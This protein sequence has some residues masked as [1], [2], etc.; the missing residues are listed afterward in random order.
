MKNLAASISLGLCCLLVTSAYSQTTF[1]G[2]I[3]ND[4]A[5]TGNWSNGLPAEGND[6]TIPEGL[7]VENSGVVE[8]FG[9]GGIV[10]PST[11][12]SNYGTI[13]NLATIE[14]NGNIY[15][16][17]EGVISNEGT[18]END[19]NIS[20]D[21]G[22]IHNSAFAQ[23]NN[24]LG[25]ITNISGGEIN[26]SGAIDNLAYGTILNLTSCHIVNH[27][28]IT[29][30]QGVAEISNYGVIDNY[31]TISNFENVLNYSGAVIHQC[32]T[33]IGSGPSWNDYTTENCPVFG[34]TDSTACNYDLSAN[35][36]DG[37]CF[38]AN[39]VFDC[40]GNCQIDLN[41]NGV[42]DQL[43]TD[44]CSGPGCCGNGTLWDPGQGVCV[45]FDQCPAD[46]NEDQVVDA[47]DILALIASYGSDC[48]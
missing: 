40:E 43:E 4:W 25:S 48:P 22:A 10:T 19:G 33:W 42:C 27:G 7:T 29:N 46:V 37:S 39:A 17:N 30:H 32:G 47:L 41:N 5:D 6:A 14:N 21:G 24:F 11:T 28:T 26:N 20:N 23:I 35:S 45:A 16:F 44:G 3:S 1:T 31:G 34:C 13:I 38:F 18:I 2:A 15:N 12:I 36:D 8:I 9:P